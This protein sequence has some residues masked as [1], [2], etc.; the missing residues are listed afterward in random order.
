LQTVP[1]Y[2]IVKI[3]Y[4]IV[5]VCTRMFVMDSVENLK[6]IKK[7]KTFVIKLFSIG[8]ES[9][10]VGKIINSSQKRTLNVLPP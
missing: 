7:Y 2:V 5:C 6:E 8:R 4:C 1:V 10:S 9:V 3:K